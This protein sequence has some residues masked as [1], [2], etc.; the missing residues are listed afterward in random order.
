[1]KRSRE[2]GWRNEAVL[3]YEILKALEKLT[4]IA[5][6]TVTTTTTVP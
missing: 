6:G 2:T 5:G 3:L 1:M 4:K